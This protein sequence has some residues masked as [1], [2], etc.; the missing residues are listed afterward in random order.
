MLLAGV[1]GTATASTATPT[2][3]AR[4][5]IFEPGPEL[6]AI[7]RGLGIVAHSAVVIAASRSMDETASVLARGSFRDV[8]S[9]IKELWTSD[10]FYEKALIGGVCDGMYY[11]YQHPNGSYTWGSWHSFLI[12]WARGYAEKLAIPFEVRNA[13]N[14]VNVLMRSWT[15]ASV[16]SSDTSGRDAYFYWRACH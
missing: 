13:R 3:D 16:P 11:V 8:R 1:A 5:D 2:R 4:V 12:K 7:L 10:D 15:I 14:K 9:A 6:E